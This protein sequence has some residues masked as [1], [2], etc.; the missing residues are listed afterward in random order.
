MK[1]LDVL[2]GR[3]RKG[4][5]EFLL[6]LPAADQNAFLLVSG[7]VVQLEAQRSRFLRFHQVYCY[8]AVS[9]GRLKVWPT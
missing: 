1:W 2:A 7:M 4:D 6:V 9:R 3:V 5:N 8:M